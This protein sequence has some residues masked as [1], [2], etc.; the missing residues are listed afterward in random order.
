MVK[1]AALQTEAPLDA[2]P[3][4]AA[5][6]LTVWRDRF[7]RWQERDLHGAL[8]SFTILADVT[9][10]AEDCTF[11]ADSRALVARYHG[12]PF[13]AVA[14]S[15]PHSHTDGLYE[16]AARVARLS[17]RLVAPQE[18]FV[19][20]VAEAEWPL[21]R[22]SYAVLDVQPEWQMTFCGNAG[23]LDPA[24]AERLG[25]QDLPAMTALAHQEGMQAFDRDPLIRGPW[26]GVRRCGELVAQG[27][28]HLL[29]AR[30][31]E[32][33]NIV[34]ARAY[35]R[36]GYAAHVVAGLVRDLERRGRRVF[37]HV[38]KNNRSAVSL[39]ECLGFE[40][41]RTMLLAQCRLSESPR[42]AAI[43]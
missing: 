43:S 18:T 21:L 25:P 38:L 13:P 41:T 17:R 30:A 20:L 42:S 36:Q 32:I 40:K 6:N 2:D 29:L 14:F 19:C 11:S 16:A 31:A 15:A 22:S 39:Y 33:G 8:A 35:R 9:T 28:T 5:G 1:R 34:T 23:E 37:L 26:Y 10:L 12:L 7:L 24:G 4:I 27:G 3:G